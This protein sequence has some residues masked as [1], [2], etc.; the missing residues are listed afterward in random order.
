MTGAGGAR[1]AVSRVQRVYRHRDTGVWGMLPSLPG[2]GPKVSL[3][4]VGPRVSSKK[5]VQ[6]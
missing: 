3:S 2:V 5:V 4:G 6:E 1:G